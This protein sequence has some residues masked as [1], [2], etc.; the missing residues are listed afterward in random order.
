MDTST[1]LD[2]PSISATALAARL[3]R[4]DAPLILDVRKAAAYDAAHQVI[5]SALRVPPEA[6]GSLIAHLPAGS[7]VIACCVHG[8][9]VS[10]D[11]A[12][13]LLGA[14]LAASYL[15]G[16]MTAW[17]AAGLP[18]LHKLPD[19]ALP[20][21]L[22]APSRWITRERPKIDR[23]ACPWLIRRFIDPTAQFLYV[24][25]NTVLDE[26]KAQNAT[27][28]DV[29]NVHFSH[30]G[31]EGEWCSFDA[32]IA[33]LGLVDPALTTLAAIVRGADT[34]K[35]ELTPQSAGLMAISLGLSVN[36][37]DDH[38][39][40]EQGMVLYDALYAWCKSAQSEVHN[41]TLFRQP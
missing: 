17:S 41:A 2:L 20:A 19:F 5:A 11:A 15:E 16:G 10:Q 22:G 24:P 32:F 26:A 33:D 23:I 13:V 3:G 39:M 35:P 34:G 6:L 36:F 30:R 14:G 40:L 37:P 29:P 25:S 21:T 38:A 4:A 27:P 18:T 8:H 7:P 1:K 9:E 31:A 12:R 28:Y